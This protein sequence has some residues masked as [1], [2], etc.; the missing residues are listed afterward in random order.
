MHEAMETQITDWWQW[1]ESKKHDIH[2][3]KD[4]DDLLWNEV[5]ARLQSIHENLRFEIS[6]TD[7]HG[8]A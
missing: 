2:A 1:F 3:I 7:G 5:I 8:R 6:G 4:T